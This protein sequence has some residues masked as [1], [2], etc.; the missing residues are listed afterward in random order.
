MND[1]CFEEK[2]QISILQSLV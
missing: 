1:V 2:Q